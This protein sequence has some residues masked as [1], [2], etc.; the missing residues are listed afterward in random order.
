MAEFCFTGNPFVD[1]GIAGM[2]AAANVTT[3]LELDANAVER[4]VGKLTSILPSPAAFKK[5]LIGKKETVFATS[6]M[7]VI[8]PNSPM[9][10]PAVKGE[11]N[12]R[13][14]YCARVHRKYEFFQQQIAGQSTGMGYGFCFVDGSVAIMRVGN[15]EFPLVDSKGKRNFHPGLQQGHAIG[16]FTAIALEFFPFSVLRTGGNNTGFFWFVHT[17]EEDIAIA[18]ANLTFQSMNDA[19]S[20]GKGLGFFGNWNTPSR[21]VDVALVAIIRELTIGRNSAA[22]SSKAIKS[23]NYPVTAYVFS[24]ENRGPKIE[25]HD[26][27]HQLFGFFGKMRYIPDAMTRFNHEVL[28]R[29]LG[30]LVAKKMLARE[31]FVSVCCTRPEPDKLAKLLGGWEMHSLYAVE[32][33]GMSGSLIRDIEAV[34]ERISESEKVA[35]CTLMLQKEGPS[36]ALLRLN[37][38]GFVSFDE[39][40]RLIPPDDRHAAFVVRDYLLAAIYERQNLTVHD[41]P[42]K[43]WHESGS[44]TSIEKHPLILLTEKVGA[45]LAIDVDLGKRIATG[46]AQ[47]KRISEQRGTLLRAVR[48]GIL[49]WNDFIS[50]FPPDHPQTSF[51]L[52]DYLLAYLYTTLRDVDLPD[53]EPIAEKAVET[54]A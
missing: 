2:C 45:K 51:L 17:A 33:L 7:S 16:A 18:C 23:V 46:L 38:Q 37:R 9:P 10:N 53:A 27:P 5:R 52:R 4:A 32:V 43:P 11:G 50:I 20:H 41:Q 30:W 31:A 6:E 12:K 24:N 1:A 14:Q 48:R 25:G 13:D 3:L 47:S 22:L 42:F 36:S 35:D 15:D 34:S 54:S 29:D 49:S 21:S 19:I 39:Y 40:A 8:F 44:A 28:E 26:L